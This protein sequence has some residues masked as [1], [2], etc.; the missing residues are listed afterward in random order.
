MSPTLYFS[1]IFALSSFLLDDII[2]DRIGS[3]F[4]SNKTAWNVALLSDITYGISAGIEYTRVEPY[5]YTHFN[6]QNSMTHDGMMYG[7]D[8]LP[9]SER[10]TGLL[11]WWWGGR[12]PLKLNI[13]YTRHGENVYDGEGN[14]IKNVG[15]DPLQTRRPDDPENVIFLDG[16]LQEIFIAELEAG[17][18]IV[19]GF[20]IH[21]IVSMREINGSSDF[22]IKTL[23]RI[24]DF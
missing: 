6:R 13:S 1:I 7:S 5:T 17:F 8:I 23:F 3:G 16:K 11:S 19:R 22:G 14:L 15:G 20:N 9:N 4:W 12:Y 21:A 10:Y 24:Y 18:E 2:F